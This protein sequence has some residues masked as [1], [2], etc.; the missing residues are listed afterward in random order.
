MKIRGLY[1]H[2]WTD[3]EEALSWYINRGFKKREPV[4]SGYYQR[5][6]PDTAWILE[7][8]LVPSDHIHSSQASTKPAIASTAE[9]TPA[10]TAML[11]HPP[12]TAR[13]PQPSHARSFQE[14]GPDMEWN[15][16]P[17][18]VFVSSKLKPPGANDSSESSRSSSRSGTGTKKKKERTYP[19][20]AFGS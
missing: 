19:A 20:A 8:R 4:I 1:A 18:D 5:L 12:V 7:R 10:A 15:D 11:S 3:N 14:R 13:P 16:L 6:N 2:V 17:E 9:I